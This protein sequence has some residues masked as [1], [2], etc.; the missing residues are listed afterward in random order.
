M[1]YTLKSISGDTYL[2]SAET[3]VKLFPVIL[4]NLFKMSLKL[5]N[6]TV[7]MLLNCKTYNYHRQ[8]FHTAIWVKK[9]LE[10]GEKQHIHNQTNHFYSSTS[11]RFLSGKYCIWKLKKDFNLLLGMWFENKHQLFHLF[12]TQEYQN[13]FACKQINVSLSEW[14]KIQYSSW[15]LNIYIA[16]QILKTPGNT[17]ILYIIQV[18]KFWRGEE[19]PEICNSY[20]RCLK[21][22]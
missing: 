9:I 13:I 5:R 18:C 20:R 16:F 21:Y 8:W 19:N 1:K 15:I 11:L 17:F 6:I 22:C 10:R 14:V 3:K 7:L 12:Q 4:I 2:N